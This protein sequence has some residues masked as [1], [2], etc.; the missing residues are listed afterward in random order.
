MSDQANSD[1]ADSAASREQVGPKFRC[2]SFETL[3]AFADNELSAEETRQVAAHIRRC[4]EC[5][6]VLEDIALL[7]SL[8]ADETLPVTTR[9]FELPSTERVVGL[10]E[11]VRL[12]PAAERTRNTRQRFVPFATAIAA[13][14]L[15]VVLGGDLFTA[16]N[17]TTPSILQPT[18]AVLVIDGTPFTNQG[19]TQRVQAVGVLPTSSAGTERNT[20]TSRDIA[21][22]SATSGAFWTA[23][24]MIELVLVLTILALLVTMSGRGPFGKR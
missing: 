6:Q 18:P 7:T 16:R 1:H 2:P 21:G 15:L 9:S 20:P 3:S 5:A 12:V 22:S 4:P 23:W 10:P 17:G 14:L 11:P 24:R 13:L 8:I 19:E